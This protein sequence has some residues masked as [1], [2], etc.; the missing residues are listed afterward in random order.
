MD[1]K[2]LHD[3]RQ[4][5]QWPADLP[6]SKRAR[7]LEEYN[8]ELRQLGKGKYVPT[9]ESKVGPA[10]LRAAT[11]AAL[12]KK[13]RTRK[14][15]ARFGANDPWGEAK[16]DKP[17]CFAMEVLGATFVRGIRSPMH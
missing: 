2:D 1:P 15:S 13:A 7:I 17:S 8:K 5:F 16:D 10:D 11:R 6:K 9:N 4:P 12:Y 14:W 3:V